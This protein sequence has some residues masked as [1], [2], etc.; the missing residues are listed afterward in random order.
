MASL[1]AQAQVAGSARGVGS[2]HVEVAA[3]AP[4]SAIAA[5]SFSERG[6]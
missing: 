5:I 6:S 3:T 1:S 4:A 2:R